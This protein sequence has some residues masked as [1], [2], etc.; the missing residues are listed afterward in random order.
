MVIIRRKVIL[1]FEADNKN[2]IGKAFDS[3]HLFYGLQFEI[4]LI[5]KKLRNWIGQTSQPV[6]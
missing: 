1:I 2:D 4:C 5:R 6:N 3:V